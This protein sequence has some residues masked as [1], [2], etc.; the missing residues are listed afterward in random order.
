MTI[1]SFLRRFFPAEAPPAGRAG[2]AGRRPETQPALAE[3][4]AAAA[5]EARRPDRLDAL[6]QEARE[7][8]CTQ[9]TKLS[10]WARNAASTI[11][12]AVFYFHRGSVAAD[13]AQ[14]VR[15]AAAQEFAHALHGSDS[16]GIQCAPGLAVRFHFNKKPP[17]EKSGCPSHWQGPS[18]ATMAGSIRAGQSKMG[19]SAVIDIRDYRVRLPRNIIPYPGKDVLEVRAVSALDLTDPAWLPVGSLGKDFFQPALSRRN[20][21]NIPA[22]STGRRPTPAKQGRTKHPA[23]SSWTQAARSL[24]SSSR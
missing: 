19:C 13:R 20:P 10:R 3:M 17:P 21:F 24:C 9:W 5:G 14:R 11:G 12:G 6:A 15:A 7:G 22:S 18:R 2:G 16:A 8:P 23:T 1:F 4:T